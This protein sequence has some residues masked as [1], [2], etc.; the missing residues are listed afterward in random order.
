MFY[1]ERLL[2][3]N[4]NNKRANELRLLINRYNYEYHVLDDPSVDNSV[5]DSLFAELKKIEAENPNLITV[6][7]PTQRVGSKLKNGFK[8][9]KH[10]SRMLSLNDVFEKSDVE[11][12]IERTKKLLPNVSY[13]FF[14][15]IKMDGL[16]CSLIYQDGVLVRGVT[17]GDGFTGEDVTENIRT[18]KNIPLRLI[19]ADGFELFSVGRTE[20]RG[21]IVINKIDFDNLNKQRQQ[22]GEPVFAN[23]RNFAAGT[24][25]QLDPKIVADRP[26]NFRGYDIIRDN[27]DEVVTNMYAYQV[28]SA[29]GI[30]RNQ[31][32]SVFSDISDVMKFIEKW[33]TKREELPF[34]TDGLVVKVNERKLFYSLGIVGKQPRAAVAYKYAPE[35][36][37]TVLRDI[38]ISIGRTGAATP[39]A[40]FDPVSVA[41]STVKHASLHNADEI[42][43]L[44]VRIGDTIIIYKAGDIIPQIQEVIMDLRPMDSTKII[45]TEL[46]KD[47]YPELDF[48]RPEKEAVYRIKGS[49]SEVI[50]KR[51]LEHYAGKA[52][53]DIDTLGE[54]NIAALVDNGLVSDLADIY[55][56]STNQLLGLDRFAEVSAD[57]LI[58]AITNAKQPKIEKFLFGLGIRH[59]GMQTSI[60]LIK[61]FKSIESIQLA[62]YEQLVEVDGVG[63]AVA[64]SIL[65]WFSDS[66][67][68]DL[69]SK[70]KSFGVN[71]IYEKQSG[72]LSGTNFV[73]T[74]TLKTMSRDE[75]AVKIRFF[76]GNFQNA[77]A[78]DTNYLVA[79]S[80]VGGSKLSK[81]TKYG[82]SVINEDEFIDLLNS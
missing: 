54:K 26:L 69:L 4:Q 79:G 41:G 12:W 2:S 36:A 13:S 9:S 42:E 19:E 37:T 51:L 11:A 63:K 21:E 32:A 10:K 28:L 72:K 68:L 31:E 55:N 59:V 23:P 16:A 34:E 14:T 60:D 25:R 20:I 77:I 27:S 57:K 56:I 48:I 3:M 6:D 67:N 64:E 47:Q 50:L 33:D 15:D 44:D 35:Q 73:I 82:T 70:F 38:V 17:R 24:I 22:K 49:T 1:I 52:A 29:I 80:K 81:A 45:F 7:S 76:G 43:R 39:V 18:I 74:G 30:S 46:L 62:S 58:S 53:L 66:D 61:K 5:W 75:A 78:K 40:V 71:P 65:A 8:K